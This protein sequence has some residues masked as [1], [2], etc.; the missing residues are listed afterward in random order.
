MV[1]ALR[2]QHP[3]HDEV[4][5]VFLDRLLLLVRLALQ[6]VRAQDDVGLRRLVVGDFRAL[7]VGE[8]EHVGGVVLAAVFAVQGLA[9]LGVDEADR[10]FGRA[11]EGAAHPALHQFGR[12]VRFEAGVGVLDVQFEVML[13]FLHG[14]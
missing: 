10:Q 14:G 5:R 6:H 1:E 2:V 9:F 8:G 4:R 12:E 11:E 13:F 3:V 7:V